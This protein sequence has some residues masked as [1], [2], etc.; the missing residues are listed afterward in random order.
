[1]EWRRSRVAAPVCSEQWGKSDD[2]P[3]IA[4]HAPAWIFS[5][6]LLSFI[7]CL[8]ALCIMWVKELLDR[9]ATPVTV[10]FLQPPPLCTH[11]IPVLLVGLMFFMTLCHWMACG[12]FSES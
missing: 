10:D 4:K 2:F 11:T 12:A 3:K 9:P 8:V 1:M 5:I 7:V 6:A